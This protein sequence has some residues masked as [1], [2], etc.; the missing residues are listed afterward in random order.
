MTPSAHVQSPFMNVERNAA[1]SRS[2]IWTILAVLV[3]GTFI[4]AGVTKIGDPMHFARDIQNFRLVGWPI[5]IRTAFYL[6]WLE[7]VTGIALIAGFLRH[8]A[9]AILT[10]LTVVFIGATI[11]AQARGINLDCGCFG[12]ASKGMSF[13]THMLI[14]FALLAALVALWF[15][16]ARIARAR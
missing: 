7:I 3:G 10:G 4:Y 13:T 12:S 9:L 8:G 14:D 11:S 2:I 1:S 16:P 15:L 5:A 6:P